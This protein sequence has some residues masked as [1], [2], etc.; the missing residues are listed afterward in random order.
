MSAP[1]I[2]DKYKSPNFGP[3]PATAVIDSIV[4][5]DTVTC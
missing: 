4:I 3:R 5:H 1:V 2:S